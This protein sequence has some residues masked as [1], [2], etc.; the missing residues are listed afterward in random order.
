MKKLVSILLV[1]V[2]WVGLARAGERP[3]IVL[4]LCD[5]LGYADVGFNHSP[6]IKI[7]QF[8]QG[9]STHTEPRWFHIREEGEQWYADEMPRYT[10]IFERTL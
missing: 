5:D 8:D 10:E 2:A 6:D 4:I 3:N 1:T 7:P 9:S